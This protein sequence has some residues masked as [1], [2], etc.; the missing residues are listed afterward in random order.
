MA[1]VANPYASQDLFIASEVSD[2]MS[3]LVSRSD[4]DGSKPFARQVD[5]WWFAMCI[6]IRQGQRTKLPDR[7]VKFNDGGILATDPWRIT[8]LEL[9]T[10]SELGL[11]AL[12]TP[13]TT[14]RMAT[15]YAHTGFSWLL[16]AV[17]GAAEP[18]LT[19][20]SALDELME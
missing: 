5:A 18:N 4:K 14:I 9:L 11:E 15:E 17:L 16:E 6:G 12:Q 19:L 2:R 1:L 3:D 7:T 8:Q 13:A 10:L 20:L